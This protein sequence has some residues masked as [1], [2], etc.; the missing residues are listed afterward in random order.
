MRVAHNKKINWAKFGL[1]IQR[2]NTVITASSF[3]QHL[4]TCK[5]ANVTPLARGEAAALLI[6]IL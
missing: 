2:A 5:R 4:L 3:H 6:S 1:E